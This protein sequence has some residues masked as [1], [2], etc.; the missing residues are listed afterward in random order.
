MPVIS[1]WNKR[2]LIAFYALGEIINFA[3]Y[4]TL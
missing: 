2:D 3:C 4:S 1:A